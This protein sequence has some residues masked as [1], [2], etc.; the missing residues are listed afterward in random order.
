MA[1][2]CHRLP[3][4]E[5]RHGTIS[6]NWESRTNR[7]SLAMSGERNTVAEDY[8]GI[9]FLAVRQAR[10]LSVCSPRTS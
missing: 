7:S 1:Q 2:R 3:T 5:D 10:G 9:R 6:R 8:V 4:T